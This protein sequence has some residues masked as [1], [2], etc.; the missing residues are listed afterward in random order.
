MFPVSSQLQH[1]N[2]PR[3]DNFNM[4]IPPDLFQER[5]KAHKNLRK[6]LGTAAGCPWDARQDKQGSTGR[7]PRDFLL[8]TAAEQTDKGILAG[9]PAG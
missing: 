1:G 3:L 7:S 6:V 8:F 4:E 5:E 9:T 2:S